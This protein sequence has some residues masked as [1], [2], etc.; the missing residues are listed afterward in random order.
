MPHIKSSYDYNMC[1]LFC[2]SL[3]GSCHVINCFDPSASA[4]LGAIASATGMFSALN[5]QELVA[6]W[7]IG[8]RGTHLD[9]LIPKVIS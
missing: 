1:I 9:L 7:A 4:R 5:F 8:G 2:A 6:G 3:G